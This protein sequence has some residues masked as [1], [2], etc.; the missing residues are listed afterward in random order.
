MANMKLLSVLTDDMRNYFLSASDGG[1]CCGGNDGAR[2]Y[3]KIE[4]KI[5]SNGATI[6]IMVTEDFT[7]SRRLLPG[8]YACGSEEYKIASNLFR[9]AKNYL[10]ISANRIYQDENRIRLLSNTMNLLT[11]QGI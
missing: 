4:I 1:I 9:E 10:S 2:F 3:G 5:S 11:R 8:F 6:T 7:T